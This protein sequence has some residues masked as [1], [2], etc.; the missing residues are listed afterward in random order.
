MTTAAESVIAPM[1]ASMIEIERAVGSVHW[2]THREP[3]SMAPE[4]FVSKLCTLGENCT[5]ERN[6]PEFFDPEC[7]STVIHKDCWVIEQ[8]I[9]DRRKSWFIPASLSPNFQAVDDIEEERSS[10]NPDE[11]IS[12]DKAITV[13]Q[14]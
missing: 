4:T 10:A 3:T 8:K 2:Q 1:P 5:G 13:E 12:T 7:P 14:K 11:M 9:M 6:H